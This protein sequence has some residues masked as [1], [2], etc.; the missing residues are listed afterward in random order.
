MNNVTKNYELIL[1]T[2]RYFKELYNW[3]IE[4]K[5]FEQYTCRPLKSQKSYD[6]YVKGMIDSIYSTKK[7]IMY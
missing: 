3:N 1:L 5:H 4:E 2:E 7:K 6:E